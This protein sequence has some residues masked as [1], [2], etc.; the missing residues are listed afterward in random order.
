MR[1]DASHSGGHH[2]QQP[3]RIVRQ[4]LGVREPE[5]RK[6]LESL[7]AG[8]YDFRPDPA[9]R[10]L[11]E[12]AWHLA[13]GDA[14]MTNGIEAG[15]AADRSRPAS[16]GRRTIEGLA[17]GFKRIHADAVARVKKL[18]PEDLDREIT[19]FDGSTMKVRDPVVRAPASLD[20]PP[21]PAHA[22]GAPRGWNHARPLWPE[23][24]RDGG[25][26]GAGRAHVERTLRNH[27]GVLTGALSLRSG[28]RP[29]EGWNTPRWSLTSSRRRPCWRRSWRRPTTPSSARRWTGTSSP[30]T[31]APSV[32]SVTRPP[33]R[34]AGRS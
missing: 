14:Y 10:S 23:P 18:K 25:D 33:R 1:S 8:Q 24:R 6:V 20:P 19:F 16:S 5:H 32:C 28:R 13:E 27:H 26:E 4:S 2:V 31:P 12:L 11:G 3:D 29:A 22:D 15:S 21:R 9:G 34:S 30:G 17:P 7:P